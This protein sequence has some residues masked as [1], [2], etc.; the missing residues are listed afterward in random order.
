[1]L[2]DIMLP[3]RQIHI[4]SAQ[5]RS[6]WKNA[7]HDQTLL[8]VATPHLLVAVPMLVVVGV[9]CRGEAAEVKAVAFPRTQA[10]ALFNSVAARMAVAMSPPR[11]VVKH[12]LFEASDLEAFLPAL[13]RLNLQHHSEGI[14]LCS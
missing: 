3:S 14:C 7:D 1:M 10:A 4:L 6:P 2:L 13:M 5:N 8:A 12:K 9:A 11:D